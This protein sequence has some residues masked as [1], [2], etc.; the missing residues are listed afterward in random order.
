[1]EGALRAGET[2][3]DDLGVFV[4]QNTHGALCSF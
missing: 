4:D 1:V 3:A 2:L